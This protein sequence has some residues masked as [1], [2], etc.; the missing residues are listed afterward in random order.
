MTPEETIR[1]AAVDVRERPEDEAVDLGQF[2]LESMMKDPLTM[3]EICTAFIAERERAVSA[4]DRI[5]Q[6]E[7]ERDEAREM[8]LRLAND[9]YSFIAKHPQPAKEQS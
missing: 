4:E 1:L 6:L 9:A 3:D 7:Q 2:A 8:V 5:R